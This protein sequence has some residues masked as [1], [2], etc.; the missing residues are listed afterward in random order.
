M[1]EKKL[2]VVSFLILLKSTKA[3]CLNMKKNIKY[4]ATAASLYHLFFGEMESVRKYK[5]RRN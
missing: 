3:N 5:K 2:R 1:E 4:V